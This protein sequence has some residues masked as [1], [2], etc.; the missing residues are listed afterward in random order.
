MGK[1][2]IAVLVALLLLWPAGVRGE[3]GYAERAAAL[4]Q[5]YAEADRFSGAVLVAKDGVPV[6]RRAFGLANREW[7]IPNTPETRFRTGSIGKQFAAAAILLLA[8]RGILGLDDPVSRHY[9]AAPP[10]WSGITLRHLLS[11]RSGIPN[12][13]RLPGFFA[14]PAKREHTLDQLIQL[15]RD[16]PLR[17]EPGTRHEYS[18]SNYV[19]IGAVVE[20]V[21]RKP[22]DRFLQ[23]EIFA[24]LGMRRSAYDDNSTIVA[25]RAAGYRR[26]DGQWLNAAHIS[27]SVV[28]AAGALLTTVDD[29][30]VW[31]RALYTE[32]FLRAES[33][34]AMFTDY[35][36]GYGLGWMAPGWQGGVIQ[37]HS[38]NVN[39]F[40]TTICRYTNERLTVV[41]LANIENAPTRQL[42]NDLASLHFAEAGR[43]FRPCP[44]TP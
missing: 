21:G 2:G 20:A 11:M 41:V 24:P 14:G 15:F 5:S 23:D 7:D 43:F 29:M 25:E 26:A 19:L 3:A 12:F 10:A 16:A 31:D 42:A 44:A 6:F 30:L 37:A 28:R 32:G 35:G 8:D 38:G 34:R 18:N 4:V 1:S 36:D 39:G 27:M 40:A 33:L 22:Y 13:T 9:A 17:F